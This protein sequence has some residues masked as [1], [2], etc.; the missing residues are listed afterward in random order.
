MNY[1]NPFDGNNLNLKKLNN[2]L[3]KLNIN[4]LNDK[5]LNDQIKYLNILYSLNSTFIDLYMVYSTKSVIESLIL[6]KNNINTMKSN[7]FTYSIINENYYKSLD[8]FNNIISMTKSTNQNDDIVSLYNINY[9]YNLK[10]ASS[11]S[12]IALNFSMK[13]SF[14]CSMFSETT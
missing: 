9:W 12:V 4:I 3:N 7:K 14:T 8:S 11:S 6:I 5:F 1:P 13:L 10:E 2:I